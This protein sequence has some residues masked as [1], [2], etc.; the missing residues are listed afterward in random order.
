MTKL[1]SL[2]HGSF[3][4]CSFCCAEDRWHE[5]HFFSSNEQ[6][7]AQA[8]KFP[9]LAIDCLE[10]IWYFPA[11][12]I[13]LHSKDCVG[14]NYL[15]NYTRQNCLLEQS[16]SKKLPW[17]EPGLFICSVQGTSTEEIQ[18]RT[19]QQKLPWASS[20]LLKQCSLVPFE[21]ERF[22]C[23]LD[24]LCRRC[25]EDFQRVAC[26]RKMGILAESIPNLT[27]VTADNNPNRTHSQIESALARRKFNKSTQK[28]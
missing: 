21:W 17:P 2:W 1:R 18:L 14:S 4:I 7:Q 24:I 16:W 8:V 15:H 27:T 19:S 23:F 3:N 22:Y 12:L 6:F 5:S 28:Y 11:P 26:I 10:V 9:V 13:L 25:N 20:T